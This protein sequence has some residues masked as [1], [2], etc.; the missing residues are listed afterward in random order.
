M[1]DNKTMIKMLDLLAQLA[2][3]GAP[4]ANTMNGT[5]RGNANDASTNGSSGADTTGANAN[6]EYGRGGAYAA[7]TRATWANGN[8]GTQD[9]CQRRREE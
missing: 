2:T 5:V 9:Q 3:V 7:N 1:T 6:G 8:D 4:D